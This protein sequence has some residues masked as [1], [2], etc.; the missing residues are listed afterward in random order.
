MDTPQILERIG[1]LKAL[2]IG[3][4]CL[5]EIVYGRVDM[6]AKESPVP[7]ILIYEVH[8][9]PGQAANVAANLAGLGAKTTLAGLVGKDTAGDKL[10]TALS[11]KGVSYSLTECGSPTTHRIKY[12]CRE[13]QRHEQQVFHAY[14]ECRKPKDEENELLLLSLTEEWDLILVS[15]YGNG[16]ITPPVIEALAEKAKEAVCVAGTARGDLRVYSGFDI[17]VGNRE[18]LDI[19]LDIIGEASDDLETQMAK[20]C[21]A[22]SCKCLLITAAGDGMYAY[23]DG[24]F[25][26]EPSRVSYIR[27]ITGAGD[28]ATAAFCAAVAAGVPLPGALHLASITAAIV[29]EKPGT[30]IATPDEIIARS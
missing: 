28:T 8:Y 2:V 22:L 29:V 24:A 3:D 7:A 30:E 17:V 21:A 20:A 18:E 19:M 25:H 5:D 1:S 14:V 16:A 12:T 4:P 11:D 6:I 9:A 23:S 13:P 10:Q 15:D 27:D 26:H